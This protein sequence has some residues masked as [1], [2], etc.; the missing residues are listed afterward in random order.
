MF[1]PVQFFVYLFIVSVF[2]SCDN[3]PKITDTLSTGTID[4]SADEAYKPVLDQELRVFDSCYPDAHI[5]IHYK[6]EAECLKDYF[7]NKARIILI[8]RDLSAEEMKACE[9][10]QIFNT[11][12]ALAVDAIAAIVNNAAPDSELGIQALKGVLTGVYRYPYTVVFDNQNSGM[13]NY[14]VDSLLGGAK[15]GKNVF[16][17]KGDS[18]VI[19]YVSKNPKA[20]GFVGLGY[21]SLPEDST[22]TG[23]FISNVKILALENSANAVVS[24]AGLRPVN[25]PYQAIIARRAYPL[26]RKLFYINR[27]S[28]PGLGT[29]FANFLG[30]EQGQLIFYHAHVFPLRMQIVIREAAINNESQ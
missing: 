29:G 28:Y 5:S 27:E 11:S 2:F 6:S 21:V 18:A 8:S 20:M 17:V 1:K 4:I 13:A 19:D 26:C 23:T 15:L 16:A 14:L 12:M 10:K 30:R 24:N 7:D 9:Q 22:N 3:G 25:K